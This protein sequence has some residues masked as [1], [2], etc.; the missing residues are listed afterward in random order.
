MHTTRTALALGTTALA[1]TMLATPAATAAPPVTATTDPCPTAPSTSTI[2]PPLSDETMRPPIAGLPNSEIRGAIVQVRG[3]AGC[4]QGTSGRANVYSRSPVPQDGHFRIGS[5][6]KT[7]T[8]AV[9]LQLVGEGSL[10]LDETVQHYLPDLLPASY[11]PITVRHVLT[12]TSGINGID[13][14]DKKP[15][16]FFAHRYDTFTHRELLDLTKPLAFAPGTKQR[17]SNADYVLVGMLIEKATGRTW[18][19]AVDTRIIK[20]LNLTGTIAPGEAIGIPKPHARGYEAVPVGEHCTRWVDVTEANPSLKW[21]AASMISTAADL[22]VFL[23][24]LFSGEVVRPAQLA[25]MFTLPPVKAYDEDGDPSNDEPAMNSAGL[26]KYMVGEVEIWGK[27]GD[28]PGYNSAMGGTRDG[29]RRLVY[30]VNPTRMGGEKPTIAD[31][32]IA[33]TFMPR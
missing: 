27:T 14:D 25:L 9:A 26:R 12:Y 6:T 18:E 28:R 5:M 24:A 15:S 33:A 30:S 16:W 7:F 23:N 19:E 32:I 21:S 20:P 11:A 1:V 8:A 13:V 31:R 17:Y 29:A 2:L 22:D 4:W 10:H 3:S